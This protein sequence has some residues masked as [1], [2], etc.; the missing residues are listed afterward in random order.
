MSDRGGPITPGKDT[1]PDWRDR[2]MAELEA[3]LEQA[4][5]ENAALKARIAELERRLAELERAGKRQA[6]PFARDEHKADPKKPGRK[7]GQGLF[8]YR[9]QP[10]PDEVSETKE[11]RLDRCPDCG[12]E[13]TEVKEHEQFIIDLPEIEPKVTRYV[14]ESGYC[15]RCGRRVRARHPEQISTATGAAGVMIGPRAKSLAADLKHRLGVPF[16]KV[17]EVLEVGFRLR[18]TRSGACQAD[19]RL[20]E[21]ARPV[22]RELIELIRQCTVA[23]SDETGWRIGTLSAWL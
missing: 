1:A 14:T 15:S 6:T 16:A 7:A 11:V 20:A 12:G 23:H 19:A 3:E 2:R 13:V 22:Y 18:W 4:R 8:S 9:S 10:T 21:R 17:C 5:A